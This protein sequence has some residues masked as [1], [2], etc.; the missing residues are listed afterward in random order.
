MSIVQL[1]LPKYI[2]KIKLE[3]YSVLQLQLSLEEMMQGMVNF[4]IR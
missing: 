2:I 4:R 3:V 1:Q